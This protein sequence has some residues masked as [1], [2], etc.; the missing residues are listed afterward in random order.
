MTNDIDNLINTM[1]DKGAGAKIAHPFAQILFLILMS[2][3]WIGG[4]AIF[5]GFRPDLSE[6]LTQPF[7][8]LEIIMLLIISISAVSSSVFLS[9]PD[10]C[11]F[12]KLKYVSL[13]LLLAWLP[14]SYFSTNG[15]MSWTSMCMA[16]EKIS[17]DCPKHILLFSIVPAIAI[18]AIVRAGASL[19]P[20]MAGAFGALAASTLA[21]CVMRLMEASDS[22]PH[23]LIWHALPVA[24]FCLLGAI[25]GRFSLRWV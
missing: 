20:L 19:R 3:V 9:R 5:S 7:Y 2:V 24:I 22:M 21:Y 17:F 8:V 6:K 1:E 16:G 11:G 10:E 14:V 12:S 13:V 18:F 23:L 4:F 25:V 15:D